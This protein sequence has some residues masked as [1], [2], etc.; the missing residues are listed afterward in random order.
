MTTRSVDL[1]QEKR[2]NRQLPSYFFSVVLRVPAVAKASLVASTCFVSARCSH[3]WDGYNTWQRLVE[4]RR[5]VLELGGCD[6]S[7][8]IK[9]PSH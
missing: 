7:C 2:G 3:E 1:S 5:D 4:T 6:S 9:T 8:S